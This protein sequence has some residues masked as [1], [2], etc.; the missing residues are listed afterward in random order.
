MPPKRPS[1]PPLPSLSCLR[2]RSARPD[3]AEGKPVKSSAN[4]PE[5]EPWELLIQTLLT[6]GR[7]HQRGCDPGMGAVQAGP[8]D[9][10]AVPGGPHCLL[11]SRAGWAHPPP[12]G[13]L[14]GD[15]SALPGLLG[16]LYSIGRGLPS[17]PG[18]LSAGFCVASSHR[19]GASP[20]GNQAWPL[21]PGGSWGPSHGG[22]SGVCDCTCS[23]CLERPPRQERQ[24]G[25]SLTPKIQI[26]TP[27]MSAQGSPGQASRSRALLGDPVPGW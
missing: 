22:R 23:A 4:A 21:A 11:P 8:G 16:T 20:R 15:C 5:S 1:P 7:R 24:G 13:L 17:R 2:E 3:A 27:L 25:G 9:S 14:S 19:P 18:L 26:S 6:R 10:W 12:F